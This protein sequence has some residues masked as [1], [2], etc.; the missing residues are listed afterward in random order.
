VEI[1]PTI[2][3][4]ERNAGLGFNR[5]ARQA[6][7][8]LGFPRKLDRRIIASRTELT[9]RQDFSEEARMYT[10]V[11]RLAI[12]ALILL[13]G[14]GG[15]IAQDRMT[16]HPD[17][18]QMQAQPMEGAGTPGRGGMMQGG[19]MG[20]G[21]MEGGA[22]GSGMVGHRM[23]GGGAMGPPPI[24]LRIIFALMDSDGDG[25]VSLQEFQAAHERIFKAMDSNKDG[26]L[27]PEEMLNFMHGAT[28]AVPQH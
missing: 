16:P 10:R 22:M 8:A 13:Y 17:Q 9:G 25:T 28:G 6:Q 1:G 12:S 26:V 7:V 27:T 23:M 20:G 4:A 3:E 15:A 19:M 24:M 18:Q 14:A 5:A 11:L 2:A 21:M